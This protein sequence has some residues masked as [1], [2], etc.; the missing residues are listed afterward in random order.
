MNVFSSLSYREILKNK[1]DTVKKVKPGMGLLRLCEKAGLHG[2]FVSSAL[3]GHKHLNADQVYGL[4]DVLGF[5]YKELDYILLLLNYERAVNKRLREKFKTEIDLIQEEHKKTTTHI[6]TKPQESL[7]LDLAEYYSD[8]YYKIIHVFLGI[9][10]FSAN[11]GELAEQLHLSAEKIQGY[12]A[13]LVEMGVI[14]FKGSA[15]EV[16]KRNYHL[17]KDFFICKPHQ[18]AMKLLS[19]QSLLSVEDNK[20]ESVCVTFSGEDE[21]FKSVHQEFLEFLKRTEAH[22][23]KSQRQKVF[24][25][26]FDLHYWSK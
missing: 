9:E 20:K 18:T 2:S 16:V 26:N 15:I 11:P 3:K 21:T 8:P 13:R 7:D 19:Q 25:L 4:G 10:E 5:S 17:P 1:V 12:L 14:R 24:Q 23:K 22:V 6:S